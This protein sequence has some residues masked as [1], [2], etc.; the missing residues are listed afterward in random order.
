MFYDEIK[1]QEIKSPEDYTQAWETMVEEFPDHKD[2]NL[3]EQYEWI[4][5]AKKSNEVLEAVSSYRPKKV[6]ET[7]TA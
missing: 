7:E 1:I 2:T 5:I 6:K 4:L 3:V